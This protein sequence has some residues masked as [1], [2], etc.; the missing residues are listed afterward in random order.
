MQTQPTNNMGGSAGQNTKGMVAL[1]GD[2]LEVIFEEVS[3]L[4]LSDRSKT[5]MVS[6]LMGDMIMRSGTDVYFK[7]PKGWKPPQ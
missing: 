4:P 2:V 7:V 5:A 6:V 3:I 1:L